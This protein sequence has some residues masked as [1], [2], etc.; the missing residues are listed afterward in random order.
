MGYRYRI[1]AKHRTNNS[2][3]LFY[4]LFSGIVHFNFTFCF[5]Q[6]WMNG[7]KGSDDSDDTSILSS[8]SMHIKNDGSDDM[9]IEF[10]IYLKECLEE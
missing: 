5:S 9:T 7:P 8:C 6:D 2:Y 1:Y 10:Y 4:K 3:D